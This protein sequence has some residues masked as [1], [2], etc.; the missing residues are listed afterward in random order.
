MPA[1]PSVG[2]LS[3]FGYDTQDPITRA[4]EYKNFGVGKH[5]TVLATAGI[6]GTR[7][8]PVERT[9]AGVYTVGG[10]ITWEPGP[11]DL[12]FFLPLI[13]GGTK[14]GDNSFT[15]AET[16]PANGTCVIDRV[17]Q[18]H[19]FSG[20]AIDRATFK[21]VAGGFLDLTIDVEGKTE[22]L[23]A[24]GSFPATVATPVTTPT[25]NPTGG[26]AT[27]GLLQAGTYWCKYTFVNQL[28]ETPASP[29][30]LQF[31]VAA[32]NIPQ[33]TFPA[34]P[35]NVQS[36]NVYLTLVNGASGSEIL[37]KTGVTTTT[38]NLTF[39]NAGTTSPAPPAINTAVLMSMQVPYVLMDAVLTNGGTSYQFAEMEV[40]VDNALKKDRFMNS[41][42]RTDLPA[43]DRMVSVSLRHPYTSDT[44]GLYDNNVTSNA[45]IITFTNGANV[46]TINMP[47]I[48]F[49][50]IPP[51]M[52]G[53]EEIIL[54]LNGQARKIGSTPE[55]TFSN[56]P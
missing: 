3:R 11:T 43:L 38:T 29:E 12:D 40:T 52:P 39:S 48:Q 13:L 55:V 15:L 27:G 42:T 51:D 45:V 10:A 33:V 30:S 16:I 9:R 47:A 37:Y 24:A 26:G 18:V 46:F 22:T 50:T 6:R 44:I 56:T 23:S 49:P 1:P 17:A 14:Q 53:R 5:N 35:A 7:S 4:F 2:T 20:C 54:P 21:A 28:G 31:T 32:G 34:L 36:I 25:V 19:K 41:I 8:Y